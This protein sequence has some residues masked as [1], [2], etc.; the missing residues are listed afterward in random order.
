MFEELDSWLVGRLACPIGDW[1][2]GWLAASF[3]SGYGSRPWRQLCAASYAAR[4]VRAFFRTGRAGR[5]LGPHGRPEGG[6][7]GAAGRAAEVG[8]GSPT[9]AEP[10]SGPGSAASGS[11]AS[12]GGGRSAGFGGFSDRGERCSQ[13]AA[14]AAA[15]EARPR[16]A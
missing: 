5:S 7:R 13:A 9:G 12:E 14:A 16:A 6:S 15:A 2:A 8:V 10:R 1:L 3:V 11:A 4:R